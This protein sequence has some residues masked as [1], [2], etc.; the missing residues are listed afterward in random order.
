MWEETKNSTDTPH[1]FFSPFVNY[2]HSLITKYIN[3]Q[4]KL[5]MNNK[6]I[7]RFSSETKLDTIRTTYL[8][9]QS[10]VT[11]RFS[12]KPD[13]KY[14]LGI[15]QDY[16]TVFLI[17]QVLWNATVFCMAWNICDKNSKLKHCIRSFVFFQC[18]TLWDGCLMENNYNGSDRTTKLENGSHH[19][20]CHTPMQI[21]ST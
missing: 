10:H 4:D 15:S 1:R 12:M 18:Y 13:W 3:R 20:L 7:Y 21:V 9:L 11:G 16:E 5:N 2:F 19:S 17:P 14:L 6:L 8:C